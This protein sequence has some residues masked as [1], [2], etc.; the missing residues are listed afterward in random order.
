[1]VK[2]DASQRDE[3]TGLYSRRGF[4]EKFTQALGK[5]KASQQ[6]VPLSLALLDV[7]H[8]KTINDTFGHVTGDHVLVAVGEVI[9]EQVGNEAL[10]G[11]YGGDEFVIVFQ[12]LEREGAFL[13]LEQIRQEL[14][15]REL[16]VADGK[17]IQGIF[18][19]G[20]VASFP[21]DGRTENELF[22]KADHALYRAKAS[23]RKQIRLAFEERMVPKT[24]HY[25]Q[26]QLE[27]LSKLAEG[28][29]VSEADLLREAMDDFLTK[30][31]VND[32]ET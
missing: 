18:I 12:G 32:I 19:S 24:T 9:Q 6:E 7:D 20:G 11:R 10:A 4:L 27:R 5:A 15:R 25:T 16:V 22:R 26:T 30:Y 17:T 3:L 2:P 13:K 21:V 8:F 23:G 1:M 29:G 14:S 28:R 31:G